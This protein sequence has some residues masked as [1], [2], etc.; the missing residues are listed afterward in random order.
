MGYGL[1]SMIIQCKKTISIIILCSEVIFEIVNMATIGTIAATSRVPYDVMSAICKGGLKKQVWSCQEICLMLIYMFFALDK[2]INSSPSLIFYLFWKAWIILY[3]LVFFL[4]CLMF[5]FH[6][7]QFPFV[8]MYIFNI[9][10]KF[11]LNFRN[12]IFLHSM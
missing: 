7:V 3:L 10:R 2:L 12:F 9:L 11:W 5:C 6:F 8:F 1:M 4:I